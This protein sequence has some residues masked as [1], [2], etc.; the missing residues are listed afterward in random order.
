MCALISAPATFKNAAVTF[1]HIAT[2][3]RGDRGGRFFNRNANPIFHNH[4]IRQIC[5]ESQNRVRICKSRNIPWIANVL[6]GYSFYKTCPGLW[7]AS[8]AIRQAITR[9]LRARNRSA[10]IKHSIIPFIIGGRLNRNRQRIESTQAVCELRATHAPRAI[11][12]VVPWQP[13][14]NCRCDEQIA[15]RMGRKIGPARE[16]QRGQT[17]YVRRGKRSARTGGIAIIEACA[18]N[19]DTRRNQIERRARA[20]KTRQ[21]VGMAYRTHSNRIVIARG[22]PQLI[23]RVPRRGDEHNALSVRVLDYVA[24]DKSAFRSPQTHIN[25]MRAI[26][27]GIENSRSDIIFF[28]KA[29]AAKPSQ[30]RPQCHNLCIR[31]NA[32]NTSVII[33]RRC[34]NARNARTVRR[35]IL[36]IIVA[37][38]IIPHPWQIGCMGK[39]PTPYII[40]IPI[41]V[42][43]NPSRSVHFCSIVPDIV[44][45]VFVVIIDAGIN[46]RDND[47]F[48]NG[49]EALLQQLPIKGL[50]ATL[51]AIARVIGCLLVRKQIIGLCVHNIGTQGVIGCGCDRIARQTHAVHMRHGMGINSL[52]TSRRKKQ[53]N[54]C[55]AIPF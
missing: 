30:P 4:T 20:A 29:N 23:A 15:H 7:I 35:F 50:K 54:R 26:L 51:V 21:T 8:Y 37:I 31:R 52:G 55:Y 14:V 45:Q 24:Q 22:I 27:H 53:F 42:V 11:V 44:A 10:N 39:V 12:I 36:R 47:L 17:R 5:F 43:I 41:P 9:D 18:E 28:E 32:S 33:R 6:R 48:L 34:N 19:T 13:Q 1:Q 46:D 38:E 49:T 3:K 40:D 2:C 16:N 25:N